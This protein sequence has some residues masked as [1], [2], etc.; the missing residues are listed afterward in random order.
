MNQ[1]RKTIL[2]GLGNPFLGDDGLGWR[3]IQAIEKRGEEIIPDLEID[4]LAVGGLD[5]MERLVGYDRAV[6]VDVY[7]SE[8]VQPG[9]IRRFT[10]EDLPGGEASAHGTTLRH[11]LDVGLAMGIHLPEQIVILAMDVLPSW[12][13]SEQLSAEVEAQLPR[14]VKQVID[15]LVK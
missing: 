14:F 10:L 3:V 2:I 7:Q 4:C 8:S 6:L 13:L 12:E 1:S 5:L 9:M 11:A 15:E